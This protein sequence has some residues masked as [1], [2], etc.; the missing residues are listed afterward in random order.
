MDIKLKVS[1]IDDTLGLE[2]V[3][4][5][6]AG[7]EL[8][9]L[10][11]AAEAA[12]GAGGKIKRRLDLNRLTLAAKDVG[13][14]LD[15][16]VAAE[17][18]ALNEEYRKKERLHSKL[19]RLANFAADRPRILQEQMQPKPQHTQRRFDT[20]PRVGPRYPP[21]EPQQDLWVKPVYPPCGFCGL[22]YE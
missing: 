19:R 17:C 5:P 21:F 12:W 8:G 11:R 14:T 4:S 9:K 16:N 6:V 7:E 10:V 15:P 2:V 22:D 20:P 1:P 18:E 13:A 3:A